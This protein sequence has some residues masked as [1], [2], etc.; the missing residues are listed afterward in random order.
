M[1]SSNY[2]MLLMIN[3]IFEAW[4]RK[5]VPFDA[6]ERQPEWDDFQAFAATLIGFINNTHGFKE[7]KAYV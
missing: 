3:N 7:V 4:E 5:N 2:T 6:F 1:R